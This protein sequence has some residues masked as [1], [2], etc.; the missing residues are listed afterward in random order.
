MTVESWNVKISYLVNHLSVFLMVLRLLTLFLISK[1]VLETMF[2]K[3]MPSEPMKNLILFRK[4]DRKYSF[5]YDGRISLFV[6]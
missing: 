2:F 1:P 5:K 3:L 6:E 4:A